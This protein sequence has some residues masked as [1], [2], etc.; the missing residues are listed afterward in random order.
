MNG[1]VFIGWSSSNDLAIKVSDTLK[2]H[3]Y[4][5]IIGGK[6][7]LEGSF[8]IAN[9][10]IEQIKASSQAMFII[11]KNDFGSISNNVMFEVGYCLSKFNSTL[12]KL[13]LFYLDIDVND[14]S[15]PSDLLGMWA[16]H[17]SSK[18][19]TE[20]QLVEDI[21]SGFLEHQ[22]SDLEINKMKL[23]LDWQSLYSI[24]STH[25]S[26]PKHSDYDM[27][28][29]LMLFIESTGIAH[30]WPKLSECIRPLMKATDDTSPELYYMVR[31][32]NALE[33]MSH[34]FSYDDA[35]RYLNRTNSRELRQEMK[36]LRNSLLNY[37]SPDEYTSVDP[38]FAKWFS[39]LCDERIMYYHMLHSNDPSLSDDDRRKVLDLA[40]NVALS[41]IDQCNA[42]ADIN[43]DNIE[44]T[45]YYRAMAYR[46][47]AV[48][49][50]YDSDRDAERRY[51]LMTFEDE[52]ILRNRFAKEISDQRISETRDRAYYVAMAEVLEFIDDEEDL[53]DYRD[54]LQEYTDRMMRQ[55]DSTGMYVRK[56]DRIL[57]GDVTRGV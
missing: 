15:I 7:D 13:H 54:E 30:M 44:L 31:Y 40:R 5:C 41:V 3:R 8:S 57:K 27:A 28:Q 4:D 20:D 52:R 39:M 17:I 1:N 26:N 25:L 56:I 14:P 53:I 55:R 33:E 36:D 47:L 6:K 22:K 12:K 29:Y 9:T 48:I 10:I 21:V 43:R 46:N 11:R 23:T 38:G 35:N 50:S 37:D 34:R 18:G 2:K 19:K 42:L 16:H 49:S 45:Y 24:V 32:A 51:R